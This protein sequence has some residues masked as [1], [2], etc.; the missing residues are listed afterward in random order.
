MTDVFGSVNSSLVFSIFF[1][2]TRR[3]SREMETKREG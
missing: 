3:L 1:L 2:V